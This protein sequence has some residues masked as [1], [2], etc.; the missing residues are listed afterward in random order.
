MNLRIAL[1]S[2]LLTNSLGL[3]GLSLYE[4]RRHRRNIEEFASS[5]LKIKLNW[6]KYNVCAS[7]IVV[8]AVT[9]F[10][11]VFYTT[12]INVFMNAFYL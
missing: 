7:L 3:V 11:I 4:L 5:T 10:N 2:L 12:A 9:V 6:F 8:G 1:V